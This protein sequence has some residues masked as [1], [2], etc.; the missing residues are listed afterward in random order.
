MPWKRGSDWLPPVMMIVFALIILATAPGVWFL[1]VGALVLAL[2]FASD[3]WKSEPA[4]KEKA[5][6][7]D[8]EA[9][10]AYA[11]H[12]RPSM[13]ESLRRMQENLFGESHIPKRK[14]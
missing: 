12:I 13:M 6:G 10:E 4:G 3:N 1:W 7:N 14:K 9:M 11:T 5:Q 8:R 2:I